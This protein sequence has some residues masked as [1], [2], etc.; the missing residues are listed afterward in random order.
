MQDM[1]IHR[2][3]AGCSQNRI[4]PTTIARVITAT[5][6]KHFLNLHN[7]EKYT[8]IACKNNFFFVIRT[9]IC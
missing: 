8:K 3:L 7:N 2:T 9:A 6:I 4:H 1:T 5:H